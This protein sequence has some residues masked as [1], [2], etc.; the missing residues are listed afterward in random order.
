MTLRS[1]SFSV[2]GAEV[3]LAG[4]YD[5]KDEQ[6]HFSGTLRLQAR[7]SR[8]Q[9]GWR[10]LLLKL[11]DPLLDGEGAGTVLPI[12]ITGTPDDPKFRADLKKALFRGE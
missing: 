8:T 6:M 3:R 9:T 1:L 11:F 4:T 10:S 2:R 12:T 7:A 5:L